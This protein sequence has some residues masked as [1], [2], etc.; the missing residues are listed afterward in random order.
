MKNWL[1]LR[2]QLFPYIYTMNYRNHTE[3]EPL[4][5]PMYYA[6]PKNSGAYEAKTQFLFGSELMV[7]PI[8]KPNNQ[9]TQM[10]SVDAWFPKGDWFDF[11]KGLHYTSKKG[12]TL[13]VHRKINDYPVFA[14]AGAI[15]P[16]QNSL[17][18]ESGADLEV[19]VFPG[20][21]NE[22]V[23]YED[24]GDGSE[25]EN[26]QFVKTKMELEW[27][28]QPVFT[29]KPAAGELSI[30]P[31]TRN[32]KFIFRGFHANVTVKGY[33]DG[34]EMP[35]HTTYDAATHSI[36]LSLS[37]NVTS[38]IRFELQGKEL[39]TDNGDR[40][41]RIKEMLQ[42]AQVHTTLKNDVFKY[43]TKDAHKPLQRQLMA[44][45]MLYARGV[46]YNDFIQAL[47]EQM[48]LTEE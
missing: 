15:V 8:T 20:A 29:V 5:Q 22:F 31:K 4:V 37:A 12:R 40:A 18:L 19:V 9:L 47:T 25:F 27:G 35:I 42:W 7:A 6:Y 45:N 26:G 14:K 21:G 3:L 30:L 34:K 33:I 48:S 41:V 10:G 13:S 1:R 39:I 24:G 2:H 36:L 23:L 28:T 32:F 11:F 46:E 38:E 17:T 44:V 43:I 16:M